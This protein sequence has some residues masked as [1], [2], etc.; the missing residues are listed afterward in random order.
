MSGIII[1]LELSQRIRD[2]QR[3]NLRVLRRRLRDD[4][5][6][7]EITTDEH[8]IDLYRFPKALCLELINELMPF[9][10]NSQRRHAVP[11][12]VIILSALRFFATGSFQRS[13]GQDSL[14]ALS[15]T[16]VSRCVQVVA[17]ALNNIAHRHI[18][19]PK[20]EDFPALKIKFMEKYQFPGI[21]GL[22]D[23]TH[24]KISAPKKEIEH[25]YYCR[26]GSFYHKKFCS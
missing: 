16:S 6:P 19:F 3:D 22:I 14:S 17:T 15:Q 5:N 13:V 26:K 4:Q 9:M 20:R 21:I 1:L 7:F 23:G 11:S 25:V 18:K 24:I 2:E 12:H 10:P 8:F